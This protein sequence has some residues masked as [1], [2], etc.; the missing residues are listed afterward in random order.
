MKHLSF[1]LSIP[2]SGKWT[3]LD[4][5]YYIIKT[6]SDK[7]FKIYNKAVLKGKITQNWYHPHNDDWGA[8][9]Q[10]DVINAREAFK[11]RRLEFGFAGFEWLISSIMKDGT[12]N[13]IERN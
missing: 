1:K 2:S 12:V 9:V 13:N 5:K 11:R 7:A 10:L 3:G 4:K 8:H 6:I